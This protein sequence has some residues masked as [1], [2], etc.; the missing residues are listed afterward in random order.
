MDLAA[1]LHLVGNHRPAR[2]L[3]TFQ[4]GSSYSYSQ[5]KC[6]CAAALNSHVRL[7]L[8]HPCV[9][10]VH[11]SRGRVSHARASDATCFPSDGWGFNRPGEKEKSFWQERGEEV[12]ER[13]RTGRLRRRVESVRSNSVNL[14]T[15]A[16]PSEEPVGVQFH[17]RVSSI[18]NQKH[19]Y[20][21]KIHRRKFSFHQFNLR[22]PSRKKNQCGFDS[23]PGTKC[24]MWRPSW[25]QEG[26][27]T[28][29][30]SRER[31]KRLNELHNWPLKTKWR[32]D[33]LKS[34]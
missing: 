13:R 4:R 23:W 31:W 30:T 20:S 18:M 15:D 32:R 16:L 27:T 29:N 21:R 25:R 26:M 3:A 10:D 7:D 5:P 12:V 14:N 28:W 9:P 24:L 22:L 8:T 34:L 6:Y 17:R 2:K 11:T 19:Q 33:S 1:A